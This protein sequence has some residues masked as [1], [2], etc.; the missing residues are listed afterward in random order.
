MTKNETDLPAGPRL[1]A[2]PLR[3]T[4]VAG[5]D[6]RFDLLV[7]LTAPAASSGAALSPGGRQAPRAAA[8]A[9]RVRLHLRPSAGVSAVAP[10][11][12][13]PAPAAAGESAWW[14]PDAIWDSETRLVL[15]I[16]VDRGLALEGER[17]PLLWLRATG[18]GRDGRPIALIAPVIAL[19]ALA[20]GSLGTRPASPSQGLCLRRQAG[21]SPA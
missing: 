17:P 13:V 21:C 15:Q 10:A 16:G 19:E 18:V 12:L 1:I 14:L 20:P 6:N 2:T 9:S 3:T 8:W 4:L 11:T 5:Q 7:S